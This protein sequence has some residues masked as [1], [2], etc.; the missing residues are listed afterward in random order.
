MAVPEPELPHR[1]Q[2]PVQGGAPGN[3]PVPAGA[4]A[5]GPRPGGGSFSNRPIPLKPRS[6][7]DLPEA[8]DEDDV[9]DDSD[10]YREILKNAPAWLISTVFHMLL[11]IIMGLLAVTTATR[12]A[13]LEVEVGTAEEP[14]EQLEEAT[15]LL[16]DATELSS[17]TAITP[18]DLPPVDDP[19]LPPP[20]KL[21]DI[22][23]SASPLGEAPLS[24]N[25][26]GT[27]VALALSGRQAGSKQALLGKYGGTAGTEGAV[28]RGLIWLA[29]QQRK[30]GSWS[31]RGPYPSGAR[32]ENTAAATAMALLAFQ[33]A[34]NT[35]REGQYADVVDRGWK[36]LLGMQQ[37]TGGFTGGRMDA[38]L[39][40]LY[41]HAQ[42][43]I[44]VCELLGMSNDSRFRA[45]A[46]RAVDFA[47]ESQDP[48]NGGWRYRPR[49]DSDTSV[50]G[51]FVMGLMSARMA[52]LRVPD[53]TL[54]RITRYLDK[55]S[56]EGGRRYG[57]WM[58][59]N[60][61]DAVTAEGLLCRQYLGWKRDDPRLVEGVTALLKKPVSY[62]TPGSS[63]VYYWYYASQATH[64][65]EGDI[66]N[67]WNETMR[68]ELP[69]HQVKQ[70]NEAGS[71][72]PTNDKWGAEGGRLYVTC[73]SIYNLEVYYRHLPIYSGYQAIQS[74]PPVPAEG[75]APTDDAAAE[76]KPNPLVDESAT[77]TEPPQSDEPAE[78]DNPPQPRS[79]RV[80]ASGDSRPVAPA[81]APRGKR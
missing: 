38:P 65:M 75:E 64:H 57:Y 2:T 23:L 32:D 20:P 67:Q 6:A 26:G 9:E 72:D 43:M 1:G 34:G 59:V 51:W 37:P 52:K 35:H 61:T 58:E 28:A 11:L 60:T 39:Q 15:P 18:N 29:A 33:G 76:E 8:D 3:R 81:A 71:W 30:D 79:K 77:P 12:V 13:E 4:G 56:L 69:A 54:Q 80:K 62:E 10:N 25:I 41:T 7:D 19:L 53:K 66:W 21:D 44:A 50:T 46:Q 27:G 5:G 68:R 63:D 36:A 31:L 48:T 47:V 40:Q 74:L 14:G 17:E 49:E 78:P 70:G 42:G 24:S 22:T 55:A 45:P 73:L 16:D